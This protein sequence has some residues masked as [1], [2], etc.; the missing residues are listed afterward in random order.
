MVPSL[1][2]ASVSRHLFWHARGASIPM[3]V[4]LELTLSGVIV[5]R[6]TDGEPPGG[7]RGPVGLALAAAGFE[8]VTWLVW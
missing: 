2:F 1:F 3:N 5:N 7:D 4:K 6:S 8:S